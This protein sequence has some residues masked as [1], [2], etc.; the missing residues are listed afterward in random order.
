MKIHLSF[1]LC[2]RWLLASV[3][4]TAIIQSAFAVD[5]IK[6]DPKFK[7]IAERFQTDFGATIKLAQSKDD[8]VAT[9]YEV[10]SS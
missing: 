9:N 6:E 3:L 7:A 10:R 5:P 4:L 2:Y 1:L 8:V